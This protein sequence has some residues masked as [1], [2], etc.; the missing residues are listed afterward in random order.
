[1]FSLLMQGFQSVFTLQIFPL[2]AAGVAGGI[3]IGSLPGLTA[4]MGVAIL[5]PFTFG[6]ESTAALSMLV[7]IYVGAIYG[8][9]IAAILLRTPGTPAAAAT[10]FDGNALVKQGKAGKALSMSAIASFTG[11]LI[12]TIMLITLSPLLAKFA[13]KF[14]APE[15]FML[16]VFGLTIIAS[17]SGKNIIKG[18]LAGFF[19][20][21]IATVGMDP[22]TGYPRFSMGSIQ[23]LNGFSIIP[24]LIGLF[25]VSEALVQM[26]DIIRSKNVRTVITDRGLVSFREVLSVLPTMLKS[27]FMGTFIGSIPGA[28]ADIAAFISYNEAKRSSRHPEK[29]GTGYLPGIAAPEAGNN[30]VTGGA[31]V[32]LLTLGVPGDAVAAILLGA[33]II[34][35]LTPGPMLFE[36]NPDIVYGLFSSMLVGN[37]L[38]LILGLSCIRFFSKIV[39]IPRKLIIPMILVLSI[40]GSFAMNNSLFDVLVTILFG[41][42]GYFMIKV[43]IPQSPIVLALILGP[44][45]ESNLRKAILMYEGSWSFLYT[46]P[47]T[48]AFIILSVF[49]LVTTMRMKKKMPS[50]TDTN[51]EEEGIA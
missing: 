50:D 7:G 16:A 47:I 28:G 45:A 19:G 13:L 2:L 37:V 21:F 12:S 44:M 51:L 18:F 1:M 49:S 6:M 9:S 5:L 40:V 43:G 22:V 31:L 24:V 26:E 11:G 14:S 29:F 4:T 36:Q 20:L 17:I 42:I 15:Y 39:E 27:A 41:I 3:I 25:A 23:L 34:Q 30:G 8:G 33:L 38:M 48:I 10:V 35:G 32:P 46:R